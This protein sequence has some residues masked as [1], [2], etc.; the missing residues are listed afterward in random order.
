LSISVFLVAAE[1]GDLFAATLVDVAVQK[2]SCDVE[3]VGK[4]DH[5]RAPRPAKEYSKTG[6][7]IQDSGFRIQ[8][9]GFNY[10]LPLPLPFP[11]PFPTGRF[12]VQFGNGDV[13]TE[14]LILNPESFRVAR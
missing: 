8:D 1:D 14:S 6:F 13:V 4:L 5:L 7:R 11:L 3:P 9:P 2:V 10:P 12:D